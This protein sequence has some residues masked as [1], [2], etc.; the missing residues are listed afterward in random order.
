MSNS[1]IPL[2]DIERHFWLS[3]SVAR[4]IGVNLSNAMADKRL[5]SEEYTMMITRCRAQGC[6]EA[7][8]RWLA[9]QTGDRPNTPPEYCAIADILKRLK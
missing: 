8:Q 4:S 5:S 9:A 6:H 2:G 7:C 3:R 1:E